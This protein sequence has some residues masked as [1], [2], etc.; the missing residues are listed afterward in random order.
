[1]NV[2]SKTEPINIKRERKDRRTDEKT[3]KMLKT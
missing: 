3:K 1:M 2:K